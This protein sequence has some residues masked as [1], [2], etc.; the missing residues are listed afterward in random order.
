MRNRNFYA[1]NTFVSRNFPRS[2]QK[3]SKIHYVSN[4]SSVSYINSRYAPHICFDRN[5]VHSG[6]GIRTWYFKTL[7]YGL[8]GRPSS[9]VR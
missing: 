8:F 6:S 5:I 3:I 1:L 2:S 4:L 7:E 9:C